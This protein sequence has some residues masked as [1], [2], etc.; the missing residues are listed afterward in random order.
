[1]KRLGEI[2]G[3]RVVPPG[4]ARLAVMARDASSKPPLASCGPYALVPAR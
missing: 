2:L 3:R 1:M 4:E